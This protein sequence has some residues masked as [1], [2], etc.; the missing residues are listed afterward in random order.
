MTGATNYLQKTS[1]PDLQAAVDN[2]AKDLKGL[3][4]FDVYR[5]LEILV[6]WTI[7]RPLHSR[8]IEELENHGYG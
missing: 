1:L 5:E 4:F 6:Q 3:S 2:E 7:L 8:I